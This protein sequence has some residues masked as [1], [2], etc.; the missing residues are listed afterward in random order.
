MDQPDSI[1]NKVEELIIAMSR[2]TQMFTM[3]GKTHKLV[4]EAV[5]NVYNM[6]D[7][8]L[9][10]REEITIGIIGD[11]IAFEKEPFYE[12]S[13]KMKTFVEHLKD[14]DL[15]KISFSSGLQKKE[16]MEFFD[17]VLTVKAKD[18]TEKGIES[19]FSE[20][21]VWH[22]TIGDI[23]FRKKE[24]KKP[25]AAG[26]R[27]VVPQAKQE[28]QEEVEFLKKTF[29]NVKGNQ[30]L[31]VNSARQL[32]E[33]MLKDL[34]KHKSTLLMMTSVKS[35]SQD[36]FV[37]GVNVS[38]F[39]ILQAEALGLEEKYMNDIGVAALLKDVGKLA[40]PGDA[41]W[42][43]DTESEEGQKKRAAQDVEGAKIL[44][45]TEG[46]GPLAAIV[47]FEHNI[48]YDMSGPLEKLYGKDTLNMI[49]MMIAISDHYDKL[50]SNPD[51]HKEGGPEKVHKDM[52]KLSGTRFHPD[53]LKNFF[54]LVGVYPPGTLVELD[55]KEIAL[56]IQGSALDIKRPQVEII[57]DKKGKKYD[58]PSIVNL[59]EKDSKGKFKWTI[60]KSV[61]P[62]EDLR[63]PE[64][65]S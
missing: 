59:L 45:D 32:V 22:I 12:T 49:S 4:E 31:D 39:T 26:R 63:V 53:L 33:S 62:G 9:S 56:V 40:K 37:H 60:V 5:D 6:L 64:K 13:V 19:R 28:Y 57:Y 20:T 24:G 10:E 55:T 43:E 14:L 38:I 46:V 52:M 11:E 25:A 65:Y 7:E 2:A 41:L 42:W 48:P 47:A 1:R 50:R 58:E 8:L 35:Q 51:Y 36:M 29:E 61:A 34:L 15:K 17:K 44:L 23:G 30:P 54:S 18:L 16:V 21:E 3:Y 27:A